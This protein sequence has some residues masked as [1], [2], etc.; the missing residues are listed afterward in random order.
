MVSEAWYAH[1]LFV[2]S[3][4]VLHTVHL[5]VFFPLYWGVHITLN[6]IRCCVFVAIASTQWL[7]KKRSSRERILNSKIDR[8]EI[9]RSTS[10]I[11]HN[12]LKDLNSQK[13]SVSGLKLPRLASP[14]NS[15]HSSNGPKTKQTMFSG[16][17]KRSLTSRNNGL[18]QKKDSTQLHKSSGMSL[19]IKVEK[20]KRAYDEYKLSF[21]TYALN[22]PAEV[23]DCMRRVPLEA[24]VEETGPSNPS[25][26]FGTDDD[27]NFVST[28]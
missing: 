8:M 9:L 11:D 2:Y 1:K 5:C 23:P 4:M 15:V 24:V 26:V 7:T 21:S 27:D 20:I 16:F 13:R 14:R 6:L 22:L 12:E 28:A 17:N 25:G 10:L 19:V 18:N 3:N